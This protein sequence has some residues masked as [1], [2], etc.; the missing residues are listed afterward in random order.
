MSGQLRKG[1]YD[2]L[3]KL[4]LESFVNTRSLSKYEFIVPL[5]RKLTSNQLAAHFQGSS[6]PSKSQFVSVRPQLSQESDIKNEEYK[7]YLVAPPFNLAALRAFVLASFCESVKLCAAHAR[8]PIGG[9]NAFLFVPLI[10]MANQLIVMDVF[11]DEDI[12]TFLS[13]M[14]PQR[15]VEQAIQA[16]T[17]LEEG[18]LKLNLDDDVKYEI[19]KLLHSLCDYILRNRVEAIVSFSSDF[20]KR[21]QSDQ[22]RRYNELKESTLP[23]AIMAKKTREFRCPARDQ[24]QTLV[25]FKSS[26]SKAIDISEDIK[27]QLQNFHQC[28]NRLV[29]IKEREQENDNSSNETDSKSFIGKTIS[30]I[31]STEYYNSQLDSGVSELSLAT[32]TSSHVSSG[33][34]LVLYYDKARGDKPWSKF[35]F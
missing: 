22:R 4:H 34:E 3:I 8:D 23:S 11:S 29:Q 9:S 10:K 14:D 32:T 24:M 20:V 6:F 21:I 15:F 28:L 27:L 25:N 1:F 17:V 33:N 5:S 19:C 16:G 18:L 12:N 30:F 26:A 31:F 13:Y 2:L 35:L 7:L